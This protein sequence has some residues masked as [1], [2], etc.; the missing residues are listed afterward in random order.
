MIGR[1]MMILAGLAALSLPVHARPALLF[2]RSEGRNFNL[3]VR[4][5]PI[6]AHLVARGGM[7]PR[8]I[9]AF[10]AGNSGTMLDFAATPQPVAWRAIGVPRPVTERDAQGRPLRGIAV[11]LDATAARLRPVHAVLSSVRV[12]RDAVAG[13]AEPAT[14]RAEPTVAKQSWQWARDRVDGAPGYALRLEVV[15]GHVRDGVIEAP[16]QGHIRLRLTALSGEPPLTPIDLP[17]LLKR[18][19]PRDPAARATLAFLSYRE[20]FLA[21]SWRFDTY[22]G[23]DTLMTLRLLQPVLRPG[24]AEAGLASVL[25]RLSP[26]GEVAH[27]EGIGEFAAL[28][29]P[30]AAATATLDYGMVDA[31]LMLLPVLA[32]HCDTPDGRARCAAFLARQVVTLNPDTPKGR[33]GD[34]VARN[35]RRVWRET[36][37]FAAAPAVSGLIALKPGHAAGQWRDSDDGLGGGRYPY[38]VNAVLAPAALQAAARLCARGLLAPYLAAAEAGTICAGAAPRARVWQQ[39]VPVLFEVDMAAADAQKRLAAYAAA[40]G[41]APSPVIGAAGVRFHALALDAGGHPIPIL[42]SDEGFALLFGDPPAD[43]IGQALAAIVRPFP[44]GLASDAGLLVA[45]PAYA[46]PALWARF[47]PE[48]YHGTVVWSWQQALFAAG[49]D[50]QIARGDLPTPLHARLIAARRWL[51][52]AMARTRAFANSE[53]WTWRADPKS[54]RITPVAYGSSDTDAD[55]SNAAQLWSTVLLGVER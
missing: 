32:D 30:G 3:F 49:L 51:T 5:G 36:E 10:P 27:E 17:Q 28:A 25:A 7:R 15:A 45:N 29:H 44:A 8:L 6:A 2:S 37:G 43:A 21:G 9:V 4:N 16:R 41:L 35:V 55:E 18:G 12:I 11:V 24:A 52:R 40:S 53:L 31:T 33:A 38:D 46:D 54:H 14:V 42:H 50:R 23:R 22:F 26:D 39:Q 34:L 48:A 19:A 47:G 1:T 13:R 20:K